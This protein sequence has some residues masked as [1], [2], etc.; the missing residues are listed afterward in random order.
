MS[1]PK[2]YPK[3]AITK[4]NILDVMRDPGYRKHFMFRA[5]QRILNSQKKHD[6]LAWV[7]TYKDDLDLM[8][9]D[10]IEHISYMLGVEKT[11]S[12]VAAA[13]SF[14][15]KAVVLPACSDWITEKEGREKEFEYLTNYDP[16][17]TYNFDS[18]F[19]EKIR[20]RNEQRNQDHSDGEHPG[21]DDPSNL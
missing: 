4:Y 12:C 17:G 21:C 1:N 2:K 11:D 20:R 6:Y 9:Q 5:K 10:A 3:E 7:E 19:M 13:S 16:I 15:V 8:L 14:P 18:Y